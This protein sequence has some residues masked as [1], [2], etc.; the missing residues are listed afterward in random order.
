VNATFESEDVEPGG[1]IRRG[2]LLSDY[3]EGGGI[4]QIQRG[5]G[6]IDVIEDVEEVEGEGQ[7]LV[8]HDRRLLAERHVQVPARQPAQRISAAGAAVKTDLDGTE[9]V[10]NL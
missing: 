7:G 5:V 6:E 8:L 2:E 4:G 3:A 1:P 9:A 10:V